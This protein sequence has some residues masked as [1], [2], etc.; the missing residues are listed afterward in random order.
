MQG[1]A[2]A[3]GASHVG[4]VFFQKVNGH[5]ISI[6]ARSRLRPGDAGIRWAGRST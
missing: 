4:G 3:G 2:G 1:T 6:G 5:T